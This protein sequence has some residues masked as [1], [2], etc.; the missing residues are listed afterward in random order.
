MG[1]RR[2]FFHPGVQFTVSVLNLLQQLI[3]AGRDPPDLVTL[4][5]YPGPGAQ[6]ARFDL[7][8]RADHRLQ[9]RED[10]PRQPEKERD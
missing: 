6:V 7:V 8:D 5:V 10:A 1:P 2:P 4:T 3:E 9:R